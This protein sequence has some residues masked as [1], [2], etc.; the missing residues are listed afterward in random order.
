MTREEMLERLLE[1]P[2]DQ[3]LR[4]RYA[5]LLLDNREYEPSLKQWRLLLQQKAAAGPRI[6]IALCLSKLERAEES[7]RELELARAEA[8]FDADDPR[9]RELEGRERRALRVI[10]GG[11]KPATVIPIE[12]R[13]PVR[14]GDVV[15]MDELK[16][17]LR[18]RIIEP[19][20]NP[21]L[22][23]RFKR[24]S[25]GGVLLYG[26]PGCGK[27]LIARAIAGECRATF[28]NVGISDVM[29][30][31][32]G[33]SERN[34]AALFD[35]ARGQ[36]PAVLFFDELDA[37]A[38]AR[39]KAQ[40]EHT[41]RIVNE[42]LNQLDGIGKEN[43]DVLVLAATNMPWDVDSAM[44]RPGRFDRQVFVPPPDASA[45]AEMFR[46]KLRGSPTGDIAYDE[47]A[48]ASEHFSGA[49]IDGVIDRAKDHVLAEIMDGGS[50][51]PIRDADLRQ[52]LGESEPSTLEWL[53][54]AQ[55]LVKYGGRD[56]AYKDV[57]EYL[58]RVR[59]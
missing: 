39:S 22:F 41:R 12:S 4:R 9:L 19:F 43:L 58:R 10:E 51:R 38:F 25:G 54:T 26:P 32:M 31:W 27:T 33:E 7:Q 2:F 14:F 20:V 55:N 36:R 17:V 3:E 29:N 49:D 34:L 21:G 37:L 16:K 6:A 18:L 13:V 42:F 1:E 30:L 8:D 46:V 57:E 52:A 11:Q 56:N 24:K 50:E 23:Q 59:F 15:G 5:E 45:R 40:S 44:K 35:K 48:R 53:K 28:V 47:L